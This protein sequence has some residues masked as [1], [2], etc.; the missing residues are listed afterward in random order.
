MR[1]RYRGRRKRSSTQKSVEKIDD[2]STIHSSD[3]VEEVSAA[4]LEKLR[5]VTVQESSP[6]G[7]AASTTPSPT[8]TQTQ[9]SDHSCLDLNTS[10][11]ARLELLEAQG[12][13]K[14]RRLRKSKLN[15]A[16]F[17]SELQDSASD[18]NMQENEQLVIISPKKMLH[19]LPVSN[20]QDPGV[21]LTAE[22]KKMP[23][24]NS[25]ASSNDCREAQ[26]ADS[27]VTCGIVT[28]MDMTQ[29]VSDTIIQQNRTSKVGNVECLQDECKTTQ[30]KKKFFKTK[31]QD[32]VD[33]PPKA[34]ERTPFDLSM[35]NESVVN[36]PPF[37]SMRTT[38][39][40]NLQPLLCGSGDEPITL[41]DVSVVLKDVIKESRC[42][43]TPKRSGRVSQKG[44]HSPKGT[45]LLSSA[46]RSKRARRT[47][48][49]KVCDCSEGSDEFTW[50]RKK[51][52]KNELQLPTPAGISV[53]RSK[54]KS[55][56]SL[57]NDL[58]DMHRKT[59]EAEITN[60]RV[61]LDKTVNTEI[62]PNCYVR[63]QRSSIMETPRTDEDESLGSLFGDP[64]VFP[65]QQQ[66]LSKNHKGRSTEMR[67][68]EEEENKADDC[69]NSPISREG[70][71]CEFWT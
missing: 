51:V 26:S 13:R 22:N 60:A 50:S 46:G 43:D 24:E 42:S 16:T 8:D 67:T 5:Q 35:L 27:N 29:P 10:V 57:G 39:K 64:R 18:I 1:G 48:Q 54:K 40:E 19:T 63:I 12:G 11:L 59:E 49:Y 70:E 20:A 53:R 23:S 34:V 31:E 14:S 58:D 56:K 15:I 28:N 71:K 38:E 3:Q 47:L 36:L 65:E 66:L 37:S 32:S 44:N 17:D 69:S 21:S 4:D 30:T 25:P 45:P 41:C 7:E 62:L 33:E 55:V 52:K 9:S 6:P 2:V 68:S 61:L